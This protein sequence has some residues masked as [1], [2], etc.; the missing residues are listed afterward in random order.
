M[1]K[2]KAISDYLNMS[3]E[4]EQKIISESINGKMRYSDCVFALLFAIKAIEKL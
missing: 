1:S 3:R 2:I 4:E